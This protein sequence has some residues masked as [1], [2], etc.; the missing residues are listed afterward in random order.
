MRGCVVCDLLGSDQK[1][2]NFNYTPS[3]GATRI[4]VQLRADI[5]VFHRPDWLLFACP[6]Q[7]FERG[8]RRGEEAI[9]GTLLRR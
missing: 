4:A 3:P 8:G 1:S 6:S 9:P 5:Q 7:H 2:P